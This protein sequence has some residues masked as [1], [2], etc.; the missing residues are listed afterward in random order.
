MPSGYSE[1]YYNFKLTHCGG[2]PEFFK[3]STDI[4]NVHK[5]PK[6]SIYNIINKKS[7]RKFK[8]FQIEKVKIPCYVLIENDPRQY[9]VWEKASDKLC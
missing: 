9:T 7:M 5:I 6:N 8:E 1:S 4:T 2:E 3:M